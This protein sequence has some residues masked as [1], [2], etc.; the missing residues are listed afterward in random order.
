M[1]AAGCITSPALSAEREALWRRV[2]QADFLN[3]SEKR[4]MLGLPPRE[5]D[6]E[7]SRK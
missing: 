3:E 4:A 2:A 6:D 7:G 1:N 5:P